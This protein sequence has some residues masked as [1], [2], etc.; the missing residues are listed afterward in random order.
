MDLDQALN[1][2]ENEF[3]REANDNEAFDIIVKNGQNN[4]KTT[5]YVTPSNTLGQVFTATATALGFNTEKTN[6]IFVNELTSQSATVP[7]V[8]LKEFQVSENTVVSIEQDGKVA[9]L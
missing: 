6:N 5:L 2:V 4:V 1:A 7:A 9:A 3:T 8:T